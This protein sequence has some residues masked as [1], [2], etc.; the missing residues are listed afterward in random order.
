MHRWLLMRSLGRTWIAA[1]AIVAAAVLGVATIVGLSKPQGSLRSGVVGI[2]DTDAFDVGNDGPWTVGIPICLQPDG[3][4]ATIVAV[5]A[6]QTAGDGL[7]YIGADVATFSGSGRRRF[8]SA[9]SFP[10]QVHDP[11]LAHAYRLTPAVGFIVGTDSTCS[12]IDPVPRFIELLVG[13]ASQGRGGGWMGVAIDY[14][15]GGHRYTLV[16]SHDIVACGPA[17]PTGYCYSGP[18]ASPSPTGS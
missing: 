13:A 4:P 16:A 8:G 6:G 11:T 9:N 7:R 12:P 15:A 17:A 10:P 14:T 2:T 18:T 1:I 3:A 5:R